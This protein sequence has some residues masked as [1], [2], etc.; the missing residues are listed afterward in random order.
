M[1][2]MLHEVHIWG[3][4]SR[5]SELAAAVLRA[6]LAKLDGIVQHM[7]RSKAR[8]KEKLGDL[9]GLRKLLRELEAPDGTRLRL[10]VLMT[11]L[12]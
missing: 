11:E 2:D 8:I 1:P 5:M 6:Q 3:A 12:R 10:P 7:R 9:V 4:G